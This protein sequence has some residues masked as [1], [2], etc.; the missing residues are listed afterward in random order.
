MITE[1]ERLPE[2]FV[3]GKGLY[4]ANLSASS[5]VGTVQS[6]EH[7]LRSL[8]KMLA[9]QWERVAR[10]EKELGDYEVQNGRPFEHEKRLQELLQRQAEL[11]HLLDLNKSD[12][13]AAQPEAEP[14]SERQT[15]GLAVAATAFMRGSGTAIRDMAITQRTAPPN[16]SITGRAVAKEG[17]FV[18]IATAANSF[19]VVGL[20]GATNDIEV[21]EKVGVRLHQGVATL[22]AGIAG[23]ER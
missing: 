18:A 8:D 20:N 15:Q 3:R 9:E 13:Q 1:D 23:R 6:I 11:V 4:S 19:V 21:G 22:E 2:L 12:Q 7:T 17:G 10:L 14:A 16:G 5:P